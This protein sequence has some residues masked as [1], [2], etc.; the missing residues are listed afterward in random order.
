MWTNV[1]VVAAALA[2]AL[3]SSRPAV[4]DPASGQPITLADA[5]RCAKDATSFAVS[6]RGVLARRPGEAAPVPVGMRAGRVVCGE[7]QSAAEPAK[8]LVL[9]P[10]GGELTLRVSGRTIEGLEADG[11][12]RFLVDAVASCPVAVGEPVVRAAEL[13]P[14]GAVQLILGKHTFATLDAT[15]GS[16]RCQGAD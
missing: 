9:Y 6:S 3:P 13:G 7:A 8:E 4:K 12:R 5:R 14:S 15:S 11:R 2:A 16:V 1:L 10:A